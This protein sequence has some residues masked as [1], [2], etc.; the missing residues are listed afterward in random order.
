MKKDRQQV[1][2]DIVEREVIR[3]QSQLSQ[4][5]RDHGFSSVTQATVSRDIRDLNLSKERG[6]DG[7]LRYVAPAVVQDSDFVKRMKNIFQESVIQCD[8]AL[9]IVV[10]KTLPGMAMAACSAID[11]MKLDGVVGTLAGDDT[12]FLVLR[13]IGKA[14]KFM[15]ELRN[16]LS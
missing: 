1:L 13:D 11:S 7:Q 2:I 16:I 8:C 12:I 9:N 10:L 3:N 14:Q 15:T 6:N 4:A 5:L